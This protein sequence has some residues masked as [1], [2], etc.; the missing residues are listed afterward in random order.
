MK[1]I[2][3]KLLALSLVGVLLGNV[4]CKDYDDDIDDLNKRVTDLTA[5]VDKLQALIDAGSVITSV[6]KGSE[7]IVVALSDGS[8]YT[9]TNGQDGKDAVV[10]TI[11]DDGF[12]Y[13][14][15]TKTGYKAIGIDGKDGKDGADGKDGVD[16][17]DGKD[18]ADGED[19]TDGVNGCYYVPNTA[20]GCFDIYRDGKL[21][22]STDISWTTAA[23]VRAVYA[24]NE[25][26][27]SNI[28]GYEGEIVLTLGAQLGSV[29]FVP[30]RVNPA[31]TTYPTT[32]DPFYHIES[33]ISEDKY[34]ADGTFIPQYSWDKSNVVKFL[35][36]L[37]PSEAYVEGAKAA[38]IDRI[39]EVSR[40]AGDS[41]ALL[42][43]VSDDFKTTKGEVTVEGTI[44]ARKLANQ[45]EYNIAALQVWEGQNPV[46]SDYLYAASDKIDAMIA[47]KKKT[48]GDAGVGFF[49]RTKSEK[50]AG[51]TA[52]AKDAFVKQFA[53][54]VDAT[55]AHFKF[56]YNAKLDLR[57]LVELYSETLHEYLVDV[58]FRGI[59]YKFSKP[60]FYLADDDKQTNQQAY[61]DVTTAGV[62]ECKSE[63]G[64]SAIGRKPIVRVDACIESNAGAEELFASAYIKLEILPYT[65][66]VDERQIQI[67]GLTDYNYREIPA[68]G[69]T[70]GEM[71]WDEVSKQLYAV[72]HLTA[73]T[74]WT[75]YNETYDVTVTTPDGTEHANTAHADQLFNTTVAGVNVQIN[76]NALDEQSAYIKVQATNAIK[77]QHTYPN[78][79]DYKVVITILSKDKALHGDLILTKEFNVTDNHPMYTF[80][81][82]KHY[83]LAKVKENFP[84]IATT[85]IKNPDIIVTTGRIVD[86]EP[87]NVWEMTSS[88]NGYFID[89]NN[90]E[91]LSYYKTYN[92]VPNV[93]DLTFEWKNPTSAARKHIALARN[94]DQ[95]DY[96]VSLTQA[97][98]VPEIVEP[99]KVVQGLA[100]GE[101][102]EHEFDLVFY[103]PFIAQKTA[104][105]SIN[106]FERSYTVETID[107]VGVVEAK[108]NGAIY[109]YNADSKA[110]ELSN[111]AE[112]N[113]LLTDADVTVVYSFVENADYQS[114]NKE[115]HDSLK[116][117]ENTGVITWKHGSGSEYVN[118]KTLTVEAKVSFKNNVIITCE[119]PVVMKVK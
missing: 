96:I 48:N 31:F 117:D 52:A 92:V 33:Y 87:D 20:T 70:V 63:Y 104:G 62:V 60:E 37:N 93:S 18:G 89:V 2:W 28:D 86:G 84:W 115:N 83:T 116:I 3:R 14:D 101:E 90:K 43:L 72:E 118:E 119:I 80:K 55:A 82:D 8:S 53:G 17:T 21:V 46:T 105:V 24:G 111:K 39:V 26:T 110:L 35:Y 99:I 103:N 9:L 102:C 113:Y 32:T 88:V 38:F 45:P 75:A 106:V 66:T 15:G 7:G 36:R 25:L 78:G 16:G 59:T 4:A 34:L 42:N 6:Q 1:K 71:G 91:L 22:E 65:A 69:K 19:G 56:A 107:K 76:L 94:N 23:G 64:T 50:V 77:T 97:M 112:V 100:N 73:A 114:Y 44:N 30:G 61:I 74:F 81:E 47:N 29:G 54:K 5:S 109:T 58:G 98:E 85:D 108:T 40:A 49:D 41:K 11:G 13:K 51:S 95:T 67:P 27:L 12:W 57:P 79:A 10:W 68:A